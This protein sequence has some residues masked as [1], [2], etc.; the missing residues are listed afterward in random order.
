LSSKKKILLTAGGALAI[1]SGVL[2]VYSGYRSQGM[3]ITALK[4]IYQ[5]F[6]TDI[7][8]TLQYISNLSINALAV[9]ISLGGILVVLGGLIIL[10][11]HIFV[12][13]VLIGLGGGVGFLGILIAVGIAFYGSGLSGITSHLDYWVGI[14]LASFASYIAKKGR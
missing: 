6:G 5:K 2:I 3:M 7:P 14:L 12:G 1:L 4:Y 11:N 13:R 9:I 8:R 10:A